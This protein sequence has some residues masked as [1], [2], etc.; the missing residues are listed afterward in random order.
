VGEAIVAGTTDIPRSAGST[1]R[2]GED[3]LDAIYGAVIDELTEVGYQ[4]FTIEGVA[5]RAQTGKAAIYRR[6]ADR[7][8]LVTAALDHLL[9]RLEEL[10]DTG[11]IREDLLVV[12]RTMVA[13]FNSPAGVALQR[14]FAD[15]ARADPAGASVTRVGLAEIKHRVVG[16]RQTMLAALLERGVQRGQVRPGAVCQRVLDTGPSLLV[17]QCLVRGGTVADADV[18]GIIDEVLLPLIR[19]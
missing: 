2:R 12:F 17:G 6:F 8:E 16:R 14:I 10:P 4:G 1:R 15:T 7:E 19:S 13:F 11:S 9:P 18:V 3:L 5:K